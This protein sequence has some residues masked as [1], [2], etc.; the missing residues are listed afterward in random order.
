MKTVLVVFL[1][2]LLAGCTVV[3]VQGNTLEVSAGFE[4]HGG[5]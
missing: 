5:E 1:I 4:K 2:L 3:V